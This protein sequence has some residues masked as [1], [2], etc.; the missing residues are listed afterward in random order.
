MVN[1]KFSVVTSCLSVL[2]SLLLTPNA[3]TMKTHIVVCVTLHQTCIFFW[4]PGTQRMKQLHVTEV[5][6]GMNER[7]ELYLSHM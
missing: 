7:Q 4:T 3:D 6:K 5:F 2:T 1:P